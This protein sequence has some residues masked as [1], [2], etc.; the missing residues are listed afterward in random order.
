MKKVAGIII[1]G[2]IILSAHHAMEYIEMESYSTAPKNQKVFHLHYDYFVEEKDNPDFDHWELTPGISYGI[3]DYIMFDAHTHFAKFGKGHTINNIELSP[4]IEAAAFSLQLRAKK[5]TFVDFAFVLSYETPFKRSREYLDGKEVFEG[6][7]ILSKDFGVHSNIC[8][9]LNFI[10]DGD[11]FLKEWA[12]GIKNPLS[13]DPH[14]IAGGIEILGDY[15]GSLFFLPGIY[16]PIENSIIKTG[17]GFGNSK[18][19]NLRA[20]LTLMYR[21]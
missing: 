10:K 8:F 14:G 6:K 20:N 9:N 18:S 15:E 2:V 4:F 12:F 3:T 1:G 7:I 19:T 21:F 16:I 11:E 5:F 17:I 13:S